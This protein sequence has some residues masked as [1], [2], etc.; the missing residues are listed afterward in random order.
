M[1]K[2][3][4]EAYAFFNCSASKEQI[5][6]ELPFVR[7]ASECSGGLEFSLREVNNLSEDKSTEPKLRDIQ[8]TRIYSTYPSRHRA[9][10]ATARPTRIGD[11]KYAIRARCSGKTSEETAQMLGDVVNG[12][13]TIFDGGEVFTGAIVGRVDG[14]YGF[15]RNN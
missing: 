2:R 12:A 7:R 10:M 1:E 13:Y 8:S 6:R 15:W 11:L 5:E 4:G 3:T 14:E 9:L